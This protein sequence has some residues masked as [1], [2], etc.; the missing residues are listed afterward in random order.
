MHILY[1]NGIKN[2]RKAGKKKEGISGCVLYTGFIIRRLFTK[3]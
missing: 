3:V 1:F 2:E